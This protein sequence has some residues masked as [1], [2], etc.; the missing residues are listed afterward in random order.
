MTMTMEMMD[1]DK[2]LDSVE[3]LQNRG[4]P[5]AAAR[6]GCLALGLELSEVN[7][8]L[9]VDRCNARV[10]SQVFQNISHCRNSHA[11]LAESTL[12]SIVDAVRMISMSALTTAIRDF[13]S[14]DWCILVLS[15]KYPGLTPP[16]SLQHLKATSTSQCTSTSTSG[17]CSSITRFLKDRVFT[18]LKRYQGILMGSII[19]LSALFCILR[20]LITAFF[21]VGTPNSVFRRPPKRNHSV[22]RR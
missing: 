14:M 9:D 17:A 8:V 13:S 18:W 10:L 6:C 15:Q 19:G 12:C 22:K 16:A 5:D 4:L 11:R 3:S 20:L 1:L 21:K 7:A 2:A